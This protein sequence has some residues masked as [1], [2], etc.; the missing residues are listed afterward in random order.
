MPSGRPVRAVLRASGETMA[1]HDCSVVV[2]R[3]GN[4]LTSMKHV[5]AEATG[6]RP[7]TN[8]DRRT[9]RQILLAGLDD[10]VHHGSEVAGFDDAGDHVVLRLADGRRVEGTCSSRPTVWGRRSAAG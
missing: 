9:F 10:V 1:Q 7:P 4:A 8:I 5:G 6:E 3:H 2:D